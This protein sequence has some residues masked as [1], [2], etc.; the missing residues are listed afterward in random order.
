MLLL[1]PFGRSAATNFIHKKTKKAA[2][3][4]VV[5]VKWSEIRKKWL[6]KGLMVA[7]GTKLNIEISN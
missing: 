6:L 2:L 5:G 3:N 1:A 4:K 7:M